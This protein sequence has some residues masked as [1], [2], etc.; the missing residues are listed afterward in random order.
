MAI[1]AVIENE[2]V[3]NKCVAEPDDPKP[4]N[5]VLCDGPA[6][7]GWRYADGSFI[8][9]KPEVSAEDLAAD[10]R[11][12][13]DYLLKISDWTQVADA[14]VDQAAWAAYRQALRDVPTQAGFPWEVQWPQAPA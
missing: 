3:V 9:T 4:N 7:I 1:Y 10:V 11:G 13:R 12:S 6:E 8:D 2:V 14:P 5:W